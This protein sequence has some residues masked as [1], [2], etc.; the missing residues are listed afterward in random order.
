M[1]AQ[2]LHAPLRVDNKSAP[3]G[4]HLTH[5]AVSKRDPGLRWAAPG[6]WRR[7]RDRARSGYALRFTVRVTH[8]FPANSGFKSS[9]WNV[10][11]AAFAPALS[12]MIQ[13]T[14]TLEYTCAADES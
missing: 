10:P 4:A 7:E 9:L 14:S 11:R 1:F 5:D 13:S 3:S 2:C 6:A 12:L 8:H